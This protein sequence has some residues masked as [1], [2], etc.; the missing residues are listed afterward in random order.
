MPVSECDR[1][2]QSGILVDKVRN[3]I[4]ERARHPEEGSSC[5]EAR[6]EERP[7]ALFSC[8]R[9]AFIPFVGDLAYQSADEDRKCGG[10]RQIKPYG[11]GKRMKSDELHKKGDA[12]TDHD[13]SPGEFLL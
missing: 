2:R 10:E 7:L 4:E 6:G 11:E 3:E 1:K 8:V 9:D 5:D 12:R 13:Q